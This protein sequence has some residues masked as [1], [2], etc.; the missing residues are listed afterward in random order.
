MDYPLFTLPSLQGSCFQQTHHDGRMDPDD[1]DHDAIC[2]LI[3]TVYVKPLAVI[4]AIKKR[5]RDHYACSP[6]TNDEI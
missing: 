3:I 1:D 4:G 5:D 2:W 6:V